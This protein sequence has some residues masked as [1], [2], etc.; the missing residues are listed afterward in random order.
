M[1]STGKKSVNCNDTGLEWRRVF[2]TFLHKEVAQ[3]VKGSK[4][5]TNTNVG[6]AN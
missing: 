6:K 1:A 4:V 2:L 3:E 5:V